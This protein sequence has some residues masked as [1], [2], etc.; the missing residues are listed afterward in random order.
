MK[1]INGI[2]F[3][4]FNEVCVLIGI[5]P[6]DTETSFLRK[7]KTFYYVKEILL[8]REYIPQ[9]AF[10]DNVL[11]DGMVREATHNFNALFDNNISFEDLATNP[12]FYEATEYTKVNGLNYKDYQVTLPKR[13]TGYFQIP[14]DHHFEKDSIF[15]HHDTVIEI[16][17]NFGVDKNNLLNIRS[18][19]P[20]NNLSS[21]QKNSYL[22]TI[23]ALSQALFEKGLE[24][25]PHTDAKKILRRLSTK[26]IEEPVGQRALAEYLSEANKL[27]SD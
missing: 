6:S 27:D 17:Q 25:K 23:K 2:V 3:Y 10:T 8:F 11:V 18:S 14:H 26:G 4:R 15:F 13:L 19:K 20:E 24:G 22:R 12:K 5:N 21:K 16:C 9:N 7:F 1:E